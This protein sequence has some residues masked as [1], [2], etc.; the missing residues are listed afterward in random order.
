MTDDAH[1][2]ADGTAPAR[3]GSRRTR[4]LLFT[5]IPLFLLVSIAALWYLS[6]PQVTDVS[7]SAVE[8]AIA[9]LQ[10]DGFTIGEIT[11]DEE[12]DGL[13]GTVASQDPNAGKR[14]KA[15]TA[16]S[17]IVAGP[18]PVPAPDVTGIDLTQAQSALEAIGLVLG[19]VT[20]SYHE[21]VPAGLVI[22][23]DPEAD[24][25]AS[26]G[27]KIAIV[28]SMG[29]EPVAVPS[30]VGA[31]QPEAV[32]SL[33]A[34]RFTVTIVSQD[35]AAPQGTVLDQSP[36][37]GEM[38]VPG[39]A[40]TLTVSTGVDLVRVPRAQDFQADGNYDGD[41]WGR[42]LDD[43]E[44]SIEAGFRRAGLTANV[45]FLNAWEAGDNYRQNPKPGSMV[46]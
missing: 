4:L 13:Q 17:L 33:E 21:S 16:V 38:M 46:P 43:I 11:Y 6:Q 29:P 25:D 24:L 34:L 45:E 44:S 14:V 18:P 3:P 42:V 36:A 22:S 26:K 40:I 35:N 12:A 2:P 19:A 15:G 20:E 10:S 37:G 39:T 9:D 30:I 5:L 8:Q 7:G 28:V 23:Q 1:S 27:S 41:D 31:Q 32:A